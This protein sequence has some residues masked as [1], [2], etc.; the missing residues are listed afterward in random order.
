MAES[1]GETAELVTRLDVL[2]VDPAGQDD[3]AFVPGPGTHDVELRHVE[4]AAGE[5]VESPSGNPTFVVVVAGAVT[6]VD[7]ATI[8]SAGTTRIDVA[9]TLTNT[10]EQRSVVLMAVIG[11][12]ID[13]TADAAETVVTTN[14]ATTS[15][16]PPP[17]T[18]TTLIRTMTTSP[19]AM[20]STPTAPTC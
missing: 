10:G 6:G 18:T 16:P 15:P 2:S 14:P 13:V 5:T 12:A 11:P 9:D 8:E 17:P 19:T 7:G 1:G 3:S 4:L 20:R